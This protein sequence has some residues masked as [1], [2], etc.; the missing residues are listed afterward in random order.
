[1]R[2]CTYHLGKL[3]GV[4][5]I[6]CDIESCVDSINS[7]V[8]ETCNSRASEWRRSESSSIVRVTINT[9]SCAATTYLTTDVVQSDPEDPVWSLLIDLS[10]SN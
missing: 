5:S 6:V 7:K 2:A 8:G 1:M 4:E 10:S 3:S 9:W